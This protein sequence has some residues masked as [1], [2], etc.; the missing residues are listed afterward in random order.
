MKRRKTATRTRYETP[1]NSESSASALA[2]KME[3]WEPRG[4]LAL[5]ALTFDREA[6]RHLARDGSPVHCDVKTD[7]G[8]TT[9]SR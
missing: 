8:L 5:A 4:R 3:V 7:A 2:S 9:G 1:A 6:T